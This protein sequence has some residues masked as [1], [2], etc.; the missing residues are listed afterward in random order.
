MYKDL[1]VPYRPKPSIP[2]PFTVQIVVLPQSDGKCTTLKHYTFDDKVKV[3]LLRHIACGIPHNVE[4]G[5]NF[6]AG[7][8]GFQFTLEQLGGLQVLY[9]VLRPGGPKRARA[10]TELDTGFACIRASGP[11]SLLNNEGVEW[12]EH[13]IHNEAS[14]TFGWNA[15][16]VKESLRSYAL[17]NNL[18]EPVRFHPL[19]LKKVSGWLLDFVLVE[20]APYLFDH[21]VMFIGEP[22]CS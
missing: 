13:E 20:V 12:A 15:G 18:A 4:H 22:G 16:L 8:K 2:H 19:T 1:P 17:G 14:P 6:R 11:R 5:Q 3:D 10:A 7:I 9:F 21:T